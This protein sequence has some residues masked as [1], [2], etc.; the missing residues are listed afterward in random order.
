[1]VDGVAVAAGL[2][3][4][5]QILHALELT[6]SGVELG[7]FAGGEL[8]P[9]A[10]DWRTRAEAKEQLPDFF[11]REAGFLRTSK[12]GETVNGAEAV[13]ALT[14][15]ARGRGQNSHPFVIADGGRA[16]ASSPR[17]FRDEEAAHV[18]HYRAQKT[19]AL[20]LTSSFR[21]ASR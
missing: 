15:D 2:E 7:Q 9:S 6:D 21:M 3:A 17:D 4:L 18:S 13:P 1:M 8:L 20:K 5:E 11:Q 16:Q 14:A 12:D 19:L 10:G